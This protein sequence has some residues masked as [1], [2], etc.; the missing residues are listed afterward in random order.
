MQRSDQKGYF[1][2]M[3]YG[4]VI[5]KAKRVKSDTSKL[6]KPLKNLFRKSYDIAII[7]HSLKQRQ[8]YFAKNLL[9][10]LVGSSS[11]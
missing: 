4:D 3:F 10:L 11:N 6:V 9:V 2:S 1:P 7:V 8:V 5:S